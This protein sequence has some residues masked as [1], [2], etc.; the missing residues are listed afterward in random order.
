[1][2]KEI[3][4]LTEHILKWQNDG[5]GYAEIIKEASQFVLDYPRINCGWDNDKCSDFYLFFYQRLLRLIKAFEYQGI[6]FQALLKNT[7]IWQMNSFYRQNKVSKNMNHCI[8]YDCMLQADAVYDSSP[9]KELKVTPDA[10]Y[11]LTMNREGEIENDRIKKR[12]VMLALKNA[13]YI[14][15]TYIRKISE[16][17]GYSNCWLSD[18]VFQLRSQSEFRRGRLEVYSNRANK[19]FL[20]LC[21]IHRELGLCCSPAEHQILNRKL[22][23]LKKRMLRACRGR[24]SVLTNPT[25]CEIAGIMRMPKGSIDSGLYSLRAK[26]TTPAESDDA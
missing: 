23:V 4:P 18:S 11:R 24:N 5:N 8:K 3:D 16:L 20:E 22:E 1:M 14:D 13:N 26:L 9:L 2:K 15:E 12:L 6:S 10:R 21:Q 25:N 7:I 17:T 19:A